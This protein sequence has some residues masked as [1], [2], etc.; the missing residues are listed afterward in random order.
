VAVELIWTTQAR[1]DLLDIYLTIG[2]EQPGAAERYFDEIEA[3]VPK[4]VEHPRRGVRRSNIRRAT[5]MLVES[6]YLILYETV[7]DSDEGAVTVVEIVR[8]VDGRRNL[9]NMF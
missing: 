5:R 2:I 3:K 7:P 6:P 9:S 4:L 8:I 1:A